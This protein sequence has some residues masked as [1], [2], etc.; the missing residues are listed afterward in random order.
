M[1][2]SISAA[3]SPGDFAAFAA[4]LDEYVAWCRTRYQHGGFVDQVFGHQDLVREAQQLPSVYGPPRGLTL[5]A[6]LG[7]VVC[8]GGA[9]RRLDDGSCEMKRLFVRGGFM[10]R[11]IGRRLAEALT[12]AA[13]EDGCRLVRLDTASLMTEA[14]AMYRS[15]GFRDCAPHRPYPVQLL[16][17]LVFMELPLR[18]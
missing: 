2:L 16:P 3:A 12:N 5:L 15:L 4:L 17:H 8:G 18:R 9:Y 6:R 1:S 14:I 10:G 7:A 13:R 11:G